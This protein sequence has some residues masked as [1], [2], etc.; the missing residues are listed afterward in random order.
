MWKMLSWIACGLTAVAAYYSYENSFAFKRE[1]N[2]LQVQKENKVTATET[3]ESGKLALEEHTKVLNIRD[4]EITALDK[5][6]ATEKAAAETLGKELEAKKTELQDVST[7]LADTKKKV[8]EAGGIEKL[9]TQLAELN[10]EKAGLVEQIATLTEKNKITVDQWNQTNRSIDVLRTKEQWEQQ[11]IMED[12][13]RSNIITVDNN[14]GFVVINAGN[15]RRVVSGAVLD[16]R[17]GGQNIAQVRVTN[18]EPNRAVGDIVKGSVAQGEEV[19]VGDVVAVSKTSSGSAWR[20]TQSKAEASK[21]AAPAAAP[22][23]APAGAAP[24]RGAAPAAPAAPADP[25]ADPAAG[26]APAPGGAPAAEGEKKMQPDPF[27]Q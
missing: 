16:V 23:A 24:A 2:L 4:G 11:G 9:K 27:A 21:T 18:V 3:R 14:Y 7:K 13:F 26:A 22:G 25:F 19:R 8:E 10:Q 6:I 12:S 17:R 1:Q 15:S 5:N 20:E